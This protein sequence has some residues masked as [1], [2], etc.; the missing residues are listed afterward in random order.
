MLI[1]LGRSNSSIFSFCLFLIKCLMVH[2][3]FC[4]WATYSP[5]NGYLSYSTTD[6]FN[7]LDKVPGSHLDV[8]KC[9]GRDVALWASRSERRS[10]VAPLWQ[11]GLGR[12][13]SHRH[14]VWQSVSC[15]VPVQHTWGGPSAVPSRLHATWEAFCCRLLWKRLCSFNLFFPIIYLLLNTPGS[16]YS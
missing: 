7:K 12:S 14:W 9:P 3:H 4:R 2:P 5:A 11:K 13:G 6:V 1:S 16:T 10:H 15:S 8:L